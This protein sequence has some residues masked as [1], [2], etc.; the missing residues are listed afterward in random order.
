VSLKFGVRLIK[1]N[2]AATYWASF[3][4]DYSGLTVINKINIM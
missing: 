4:M 2:T 1:A 3:R